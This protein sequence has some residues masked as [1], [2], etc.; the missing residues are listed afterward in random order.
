M[1]ASCLPPKAQLLRYHFASAN[2]GISKFEQVFGVP[3][4]EDQFVEQ[5]TGGGLNPGSTQV[6]TLGLDQRGG[7][8]ISTSRTWVHPDSTQVQS[9]FNPG[10]IQVQPRFR[11]RFNPV[12]NP[13]STQ[14][15]PRFSDP[16]SLTQ[17]QTQVQSRFNPGSDPGSTQFEPTFNPGSTQ[18][19]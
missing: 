7:G 10:S 12:L 15:Q 8:R 9:R 11:P 18:V 13:R 5:G 3:S 2:Q 17:V 6:R 19:L 14:V 1:C 4:T 16:G